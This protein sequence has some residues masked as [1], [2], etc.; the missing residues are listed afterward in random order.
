MQWQKNKNTGNLQTKLLFATS[1]VD[2]GF[3]PFRKKNMEPSVL[4]TLGYTNFPWGDKSCVHLKSCKQLI[5]FSKISVTLKSHKTPHYFCKGWNWSLSWFKERLKWGPFLTSRLS[6]DT[7]QFPARRVVKLPLWISGRF[8]RCS[9]HLYHL[10]M[11]P[12]AGHNHL[13]VGINLVSLQEQHAQ[14]ATFRN[15]TYQSCFAQGQN[16]E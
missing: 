7:M 16:W 3:V 2:T 6:F 5:L 15:C 8:V 1:S 11:L 9:R 13:R 12:V 4:P 10:R 14:E